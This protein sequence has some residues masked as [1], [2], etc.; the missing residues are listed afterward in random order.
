MNWY[1]FCTKVCEE[2]RR[3]GEKTAAMVYWSM[4]FWADDPDTPDARVLTT[5]RGFDKRVGAYF[6][7]KKETVP[8]CFD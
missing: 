2:Y 1:W 8:H 7:Y 3:R 6:Q 4:R 5:E